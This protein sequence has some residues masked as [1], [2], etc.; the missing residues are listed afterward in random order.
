MGRLAE[1]DDDLRFSWAGIHIL[2]PTLGIDEVSQ[3]EFL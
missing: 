2:S 3:D 1:E